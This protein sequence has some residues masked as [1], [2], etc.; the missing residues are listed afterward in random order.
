MKITYVIALA[1]AILFVAEAAHADDCTLKRLASLPMSAEHPNDVVVDGKI[2]DRTV[3]FLV[4][5]GG[6][7]TEIKSD[8]VD[9]LHLKTYPLE[10]G[11]E[12][13]HIQGAGGTRYTVADDVHIGDLKIGR[14]PMLLL[15]MQMPDGIDG[16]LAPDVLA[17]F[18]LDLDF[19]ARTLN[20][21][22]PDHCP[23]KVVYWAQAYAVTDF[24]TE[25]AHIEVPV[26]VDGRS[27]AAIVDT[28]A[29]LTSID[30]VTA[31]NEFGVHEDSPGAELPP[32]PDG[33]LQFR[34]RFKS[35][36][37]GG[38]T[39]AN[40]AIAVFHNSGQDAYHNEYGWISAN[41]PV[42]GDHMKR[43]MLL[44][45]DLLGKLHIFICYKEKKL[46]ITGAGAH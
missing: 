46:Y 31:G 14:V 38:V 45:A 22:A 9:A 36:T 23:G 1:S 27:L 10:N 18:D 37:M 42:Y 34:Y 33:P 13:F 32:H 28:G 11:M 39:V 30:D 41:D 19:G 4:D 35:L 29:T 17:R 40:P 21:I 15:N 2:G 16:I 26:T 12:L 3:H 25:G 6:V 5:T 7:Y 43:E 20:L 44:G 8:I 24:S